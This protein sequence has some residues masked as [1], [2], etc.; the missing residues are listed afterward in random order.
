MRC[1]CCKINWFAR[2]VLLFLV[3]SWKSI[4]LLSAKSSVC[5][6]N[7]RVSMNHAVLLPEKLTQEWSSWDSPTFSHNFYPDVQ[8]H[9]FNRWECLLLAKARGKNIPQ[10]FSQLYH[11]ISGCL[12]FPLK[13]C[14]CQKCDN[15]IVSAQIPFFAALP[16]ELQ[17]WQ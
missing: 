12:A 7:M 1:V 6:H 11:Y 9:F 13:A 10:F 3:Y 5:F 16:Y 15:E 14:W 4:F 8:G 17:S 2:V